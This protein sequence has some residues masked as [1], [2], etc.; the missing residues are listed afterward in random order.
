VA[1]KIVTDPIQI[2]E[3]PAIAI[4][5]GLFAVMVCCVVLLHP[6]L[7]PVSVYVVV[8]VGAMARVLLVAPVLH[9]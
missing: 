7:V 8:T 9:E 3:I 2:D 1:L 5:G 4:T 6:L